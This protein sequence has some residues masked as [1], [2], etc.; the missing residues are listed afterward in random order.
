MNQDVLSTF[1]K[2][3]GYKIDLLLAER[4]AEELG[5]FQG[6]AK[7]E[8]LALFMLASANPSDLWDDVRTKL[9]KK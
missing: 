7:N 4:I 2:Y 9:E 8:L 6:Q 1:Y 3:S 5:N